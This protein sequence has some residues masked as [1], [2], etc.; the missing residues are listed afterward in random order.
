MSLREFEVA[1]DGGVRGRGATAK[2]VPQRYPLSAV[3]LLVFMAPTLEEMERWVKEEV[4]R[5]DVQFPSYVDDLYY[6]LY[7]NRG[8]GE[9]QV[10]LE[11][12]QDLVAR[13]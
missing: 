3:L 10:V 1:W 5:V 2:G 11:R 12:M 6:G 8:A 4:E 13:V 7:D 9:G